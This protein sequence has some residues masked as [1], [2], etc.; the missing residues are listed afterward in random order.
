MDINHK[1]VTILLILDGLVYYLA[2]NHNI[3]VVMCKH[4]SLFLLSNLDNDQLQSTSE[5]LLLPESL[6]ANKGYYEYVYLNNYF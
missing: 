4:R 2:S 1:L 5:S 3:D 6:N